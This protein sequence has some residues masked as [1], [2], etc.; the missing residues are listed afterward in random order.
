M[1]STTGATHAAD[2]ATQRPWRSQPVTPKPCRPRHNTPCAWAVPYLASKLHVRLAD[3]TLIS[4]LWHTQDLVQALG[5]D[6]EG[7][8][9]GG[10]PICRQ[11]ATA[12]LHQPTPMDGQAGGTTPRH[13]Y[14]PPHKPPVHGDIHQQTARAR[15]HSNNKQ[16]P[17][18]FTGPHRARRG[19]PGR[20]AGP[21]GAMPP[22]QKP[23]EFGREHAS[24]GV[25]AND[26][27]TGTHLLRGLW[28][29]PHAATTTTHEEGNAAA[30]HCR[31]WEATLTES[32]ESC[33]EENPR[34]AF[35][36]VSR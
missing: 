15:H 32:E 16:G 12:G 28:G 11:G 8:G 35:L 4:G 24:T 10:G 19:S 34:W 33:I 23:L 1:A 20:R 21:Q 6:L 3:L 7:E 27:G 22:P 18:A 9:V 25:P 17:E 29:T 14:R 2:R 30:K 31:I 26:P 13:V 36:A 5:V